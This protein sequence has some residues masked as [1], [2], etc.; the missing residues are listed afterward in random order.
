MNPIMKRLFKIC[1]VGTSIRSLV[2]DNR[3][4]R[5][6][7]RLAHKIL[8]FRF[9]YYIVKCEYSEYSK[10]FSFVDFG[11]AF[12]FASEPSAPTLGVGSSP[13]LLAQKNKPFGFFWRERVGIP[14]ISHYISVA[15]SAME[16]LLPLLISVRPSASLQSLTPPPCGWVHLPYPKPKKISLTAFFVAGTGGNRTHQ[17]QS[18]PLT[19]F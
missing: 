16:A 19:R 9:L 15:S 17:G 13:T 12:R 2:L 14:T 8:S 3:D 11:A 18:M 5:K 6:L 4:F 1:Y 10:C 7:N